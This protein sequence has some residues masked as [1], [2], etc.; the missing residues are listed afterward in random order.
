M[1]LTRKEYPLA[2]RPI[3]AL[4]AEDYR[5][6]EVFKRFGIDFCCGGKRTVREACEKQQVPLADLEAAL[7][8]AGQAH[9]SSLPDVTGW[10]L[11][12]LADYIVNVHHRYVRE[13]LPLLREFTAKVAR[14]H[15]P[16]NPE[17]VEIALLFE[18]LATEMTEHLAKEEAVLFPY[19]R[20]LVRAGDDAVAPPAFGTVEHPIRMMEA[21][22]DSAGALMRKIRRLSNDFTP[23]EQACNTYRVTFHKLEEFEA[24]LHRHVHLENNVL[25]PAAAALEA[26]RTAA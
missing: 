3:G 8:A 2:D 4:V 22:H 6:A 21:E 9:A 5:T 13:S 20:Q 12:F 15:G 17:L 25:F 23:P 16:R 7:R 18:E 14:V 26:E 1:E 11:A 10:D 19:V 24:D